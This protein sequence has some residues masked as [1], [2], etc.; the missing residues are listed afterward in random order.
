M[1]PFFYISNIPAEIDEKAAQ[2]ANPSRPGKFW[3]QYHEL[4]E[5][6]RKFL[7]AC[8]AEIHETGCDPGEYIAKLDKLRR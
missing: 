7:E 6:A 3:Q 8:Q 4:E 1:D 5:E 2:K